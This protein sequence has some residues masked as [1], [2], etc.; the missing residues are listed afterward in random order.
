VEYSAHAIPEG[1]LAKVPK[2]YGDGYLMTGDAAGL[3]LNALYTVRGMDF[4]IASGYYAARAVIDAKGRD[5]TSA[6]SL[7]QYEQSL[8]STFVLKDLETAREIPHIIENPRIFKHY[9]QSVSR[10]LEQLFTIGPGPQGSLAGTVWK[11]A[12]KDFLNLAT[13][14]DLRSFRKM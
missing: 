11:S 1:G 7:A 9:P 6:A 10:L 2:L 5:D 3:A 4:A 8:K 12:R 13:L 14:K